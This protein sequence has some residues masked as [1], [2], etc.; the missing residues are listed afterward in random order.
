MAVVLQKDDKSMRKVLVALLA[1]VVVVCSTPGAK[2][3]PDP[4]SGARAVIQSFYDGL[5]ATMKDGKTLGFQGRV[6]ALTPVVDRSFDLPQMTRMILGTAAKS[7]T[8]DQLARLTEAFRRY[9]I[10]SYAD[11]FDDFSG[12]RFEIGET[13][14][15][16]GGRLVVTSHLVPTDGHPVAL[17]YVMQESSDGHWGITDVLAEGA[18]SQVALRRSE[19]VS[20]LRKDGIDALIAVIQQRT[21]ALAAAKG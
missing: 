7:L 12:E 15:A 17:D 13:R 20:V 1:I 3:V 18:V 6:K 8:D 21:D 11:N 14:A 16:Q 4:A 2:A 9:T 10:A 19:F 5:L